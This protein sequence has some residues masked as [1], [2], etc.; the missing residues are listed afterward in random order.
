VTGAITYAAPRI[1]Q[2]HKVRSWSFTN[3]HEGVPLDPSIS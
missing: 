2:V 1:L 3:N